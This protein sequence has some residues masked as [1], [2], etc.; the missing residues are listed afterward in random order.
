MILVMLTSHCDYHF[1]CS[2]ISFSENKLAG[3]GLN[4]NGL[5][6]CVQKNGGKILWLWA[7]CSFENTSLGY[8][9][10]SQN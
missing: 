3:L 1:E 4:S 8:Y 2:N 10:I 5:D 7:H 9:N 6:Y